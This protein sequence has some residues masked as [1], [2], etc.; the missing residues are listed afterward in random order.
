MQAERAALAVTH[1][2]RA[3]NLHFKLVYLSSKSEAENT[4]RGNSPA[5]LSEAVFT[6]VLLEKKKPRC[7]LLIPSLALEV[8]VALPPALLGLNPGDEVS[9][10]LNRVNLPRLEASWSAQ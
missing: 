1:A 10:E 3:S 6:A 7:V 9:L 2:E 4:A 5:G 8:Q